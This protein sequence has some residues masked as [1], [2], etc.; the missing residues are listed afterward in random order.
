MRP[1]L[2]AQPR[3][4]NARPSP[5][6][7]LDWIQ[8]AAV[9]GCATRNCFACG[10]PRLQTNHVEDARLGSSIRTRIKR[11]RPRQR[12]SG[13]H[14]AAVP[15]CTTSIPQRT[16]VPGRAFALDSTRGRPGLRNSELHN[17]RPSQAA[18]PQLG[19]RTAVP[20]RTWP[21]QAMHLN[22]RGRPRLRD[23]DSHRT[24][25]SQAAQPRVGS[26]RPSQA[27]PLDSTQHAAVLGC[28]ATCRSR[29]CNLEH[30]AHGC[31]RPGVCRHDGC[32]FC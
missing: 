14:L 22:W 29:L 23:S 4:R 32:G 28:K 10:R 21:S 11:G 9:P 8:R 3:V 18:Q 17:M 16:A 12:N 26:A 25:P 20:G 24:R 7:H 13:E 5:A 19:R 6:V 1:S 31:P 2:A 30:T 15:G 27:A